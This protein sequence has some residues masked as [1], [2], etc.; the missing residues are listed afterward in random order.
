MSISVITSEGDFHDLAASWNDLAAAAGGNIFLHHEWFHAAW[1]WRKETASLFVLVAREDDR[2]IGILPLV[3]ICERKRFGTVR[4][5]EFL[6]VPDTQLC[7]LIAAPQ[8]HRRAAELIAGELQRLSGEWDQLVLR[9]LPA[10]AAAQAL[11]SVLQARGYAVQLRPHSRNL[12]VPLH[13]SWDGYYGTRT[14]SLKKANNLAANRLGKTGAVTIHRIGGDAAPPQSVAQ[15]LAD[16][17]DISRRSWKHATGNSLDHPGP[18]RFIRTLT[19][20]AVQR[21]WLS[22][23][24]LSLDGRPVALEYQLA[25]GANVYALRA[26]FD[27][28]FEEVSPGSH[29]MRTLL[30]ALFGENLHRYYMG[31]GENAYKARWTDEFEP[32][33]ALL[34]YGKSFRG[35]VLHVLEETLKPRARRLRDAFRGKNATDKTYPK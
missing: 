13:T 32:L 21:G 26:D 22:L 28:K 6:T 24:L 12:F 35:R 11:H 31:P 16:A 18:N 8:E 17:V 23:W 19:E 25:D 5:L 15:A 30:E 1:E 3:R 14:R 33:D 34:A 2:A 4:R 7:D 27:A 29:L 20:H 9:Y 10:G